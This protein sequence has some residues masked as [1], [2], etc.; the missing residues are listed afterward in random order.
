MICW[1][2]QSLVDENWT[3]CNNY[4]TIFE[5]HVWHNYWPLDFALFL[6]FFLPLSDTGS[7]TFSDSKYFKTILNCFSNSETRVRTFW[8]STSYSSIFD[9]QFGQKEA[10]SSLLKWSFNKFVW[11]G[12]QSAKLHSCKSSFKIIWGSLSLIFDWNESRLNVEEHKIQFSE[13]I[14]VNWS[15]LLHRG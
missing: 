13:N 14:S 9:L 15:I 2:N 10:E 1:C 5:T 8:I 6:R 12:L 3:S 11:G 7:P 4:Y